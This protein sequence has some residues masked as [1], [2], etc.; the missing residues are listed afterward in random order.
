MST[1]SQR[2]RVLSGILFFPRGGSAH[3]ARALARELPRH[4]WDVT[5]VSG[6][7]SD[8]GA[9][10][11]A[12]RFYTGVDARAVDFTPALLSGRDP[13]AFEAAT[14]QA[15]MQPSFEDRPGAADRV[16]AM[17]DDDDAERQAGAWATALARAGATHADVL[18]LHHLTPLNA[19]AA[20]AAPDVPVVGHLHGTELLFLEQ[21]AAR[22]P[23]EWAYAERWAE[24]M[25]E[26]AVRCRSLIATSTDGLDRAASL[27][28]VPTT[29]FTLL[30]NGFDADRFFAAEVD[31]A[32]HWRT[33]LVERPKGWRPG[34]GPGS[35]GYS[36]E[37]LAGFDPGPVLLYVGRFTEVKRVPLLVRAYA[38][39][40]ERFHT[41]APLVLVGGHP[42]EWEGEHP[43]ETIEALAVPDVFL[44]GW[45]DHDELP[46]FLR[47]A[48]VLVIPSVREQFGQVI[49]EAMA[50]ERPAIAVR[51]YGPAEI[52]EDGET[53]WLVEPDDEAGLAH[54]LVDA[55][56]RPEDRARRGRRAADVARGRYAWS[57]VAER[58]ASTLEATLR[59]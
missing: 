7:R 58:M 30:P 43:L 16:F 23:P 52:V 21:V 8:L 54:A 41:R 18:H 24:R 15:P 40:R 9:E 36:E 25:R 20:R 32:A 48:D 44:A 55:V 51:R 42:G 10:G 28:D 29:R 56:N 49:V 6:S 22:P 19:A 47:A 59:S 12:R 26:W 33:H 4:G 1:A 2:H 35:V 27:L 50:C 17:L 53:G 5:L 31:R 37:D 45:H 38:R 57:R 34:V 11:D 39:A 14:G 46:D 3:V 13:M